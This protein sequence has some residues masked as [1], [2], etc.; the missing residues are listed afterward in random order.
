MPK[1]SNL[2][3]DNE[4]N[5]DIDLQ[6]AVSQHLSGL[7]EFGVTIVPAGKGELFAIAAPDAPTPA[8]ESGAAADPTP[9][10]LLYTSPSPR[11]ATLSR[12]PSSA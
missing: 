8:V 3:A 9:T 6:L 5:E 1:V 2:S 4:S 11:D 10:C 7:K 12:M